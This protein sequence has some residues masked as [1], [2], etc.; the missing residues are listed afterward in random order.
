MP[1]IKRN[2]LSVVAINSS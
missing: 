2:L 1:E